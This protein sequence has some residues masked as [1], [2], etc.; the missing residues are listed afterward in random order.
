MLACFGAWY[1]YNN[2]GSG[3][4]ASSTTRDGAC[5]LSAWVNQIADCSACPQQWPLDTVFR[6]VESYN[7]GSNKDTDAVFTPLERACINIPG[8]VD[9]SRPG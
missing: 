7:F 9:T 2:T 1:A 6:Q 8:G 3:W 4:L 5:L